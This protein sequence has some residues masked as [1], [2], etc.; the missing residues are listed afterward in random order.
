M[1]L[2]FISL[3]E[4]GFLSTPHPLGFYSVTPSP[5]V[6][7]PLIKGKGNGYRREAKPLFDSPLVS[8]SS[9]ESGTDIKRGV[10]PLLNSP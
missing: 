5:F 8:P 6:P 3:G 9:K 10:K 1:S 7:L 4:L 2:R